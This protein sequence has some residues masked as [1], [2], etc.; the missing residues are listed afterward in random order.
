MKL[1]KLVMLV[2][3]V[4]LSSFSLAAEW[5]AVGMLTTQIKG[6]DPEV[7]FVRIPDFDQD[8]CDSFLKAESHS[9]D[10]IGQGGTDGKVSAV[11]WNFDGKCIQTRH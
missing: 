10:H 2:V 3:M 9:S 4:S 8:L 7:E 11:Q 6:Q 1:S 5:T